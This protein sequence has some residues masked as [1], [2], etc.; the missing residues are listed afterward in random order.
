MFQKFVFF[1][2]FLICQID[3]YVDINMILNKI[4][5]RN[6]LYVLKSKNKSFLSE[7]QIHN[8]NILHITL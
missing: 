2:S 8:I 3:K 6:N 5:H 1:I 4:V 7:T